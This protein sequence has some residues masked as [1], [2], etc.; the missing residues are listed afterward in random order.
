MVNAVLKTGDANKF[1]NCS[2]LIASRMERLKQ[3]INRGTDKNNNAPDTRCANEF[4]PVTGRRMRKI[5]RNFGL[6]CLVIIALNC[7][8]IASFVQCD[9]ILPSTGNFKPVKETMQNEWQKFLSQNGA[10]FDQNGLARFSNSSREEIQMVASQCLLI[11]LDNLGVIHVSGDDAQTFLQGQLSNDINLTDSGKSQISAYC[12]P[13][14]R[15]LAQFLV[16]PTGDGYYL[17]CP[18]AILD[19]TLARLRMFVLRSQVTLNDMSER[20]VCLGLSGKQTADLGLSLPEQ[21]YDLNYNGQY[22]VTRL[23]SQPPRCLFV[24]D[25]A[26][27]KSFWQSKR[28]KCQP[29][30][31][32]VWQ[33]LD[34]Q[35]GLPS[36]STETVEEFVPQMVNLELI[37]GVNFKKGCYPGQEIV[38]RMHYLGKPKRRMFRL[39][40]ETDDVPPPGADLYLQGGD[41]QSA[42]KVVMAQLAANTGTDLLAVIRLNHAGSPDLRLGSENGPGLEFKELPY[43]LENDE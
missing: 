28:D 30:S 38:A 25:T 35:A 22:F 32:A 15:I 9:T 6:F 4:T 39:H 3:Y 8:S 33:W 1:C 29:A 26:S 5:L 10:S 24:M 36:I 20:L 19:K 13:K 31:E 34:I 23:P 18:K 11:S 37:G 2:K 16:I 12:N 14:G 27:A 40:S 43:K 41:G 17:L 21:D 7:S 42:G